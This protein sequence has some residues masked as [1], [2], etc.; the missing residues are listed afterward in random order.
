MLHYADMPASVKGSRRLLTLTAVT[1]LVLAIVLYYV[2][3][4]SAMLNGDE[5]MGESEEEEEVSEVRE[6]EEVGKEGEDIATSAG[7]IAFT[8]G[9][10]LNTLFT[11]YNRARKL[12]FKSL[13]SLP[14]KHILDL[15]IAT[16]VALALLAFWHGYMLS[17][18]AGPVEYA[19]V[20]LIALLLLSGLI[21]RFVGDKK[22]RLVSR[23]VHAQLALSLVLV[24]LLFI[25]VSSVGE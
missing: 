24:A 6:L 18:S 21:M 20:G 8:G 25:H 3:L 15:H 11:I 7:S 5:E 23:M 12:G 9:L 16:N 17:Y 14:A 13:R 4:D 22:A 1:L 10:V 2:H 19:S